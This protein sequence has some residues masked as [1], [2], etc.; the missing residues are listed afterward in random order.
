MKLPLI[1][2]V[3]FTLCLL[4]P[5][6]AYTQID[7]RFNLSNVIFYEVNADVEYGFNKFISAN[8]FGS[9]V[10]G[11]P[12]EEELEPYKKFSY[13]GLEAR[14]YPNP[15]GLIDGF[16]LGVY[17]KYSFGDLYTNM[18]SYNSNNQLYREVWQFNKLALGISLGSKWMIGDHFNVG[19]FGGVGRILTIQYQEPG[20]VEFAERFGLD[21]N[22]YDFRWG[23][24]VGYRF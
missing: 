4:V 2:K 8:L 6:L 22:L 15:K 12:V 13:L 17:T 11:L 18:Y 5:F 1:G 23:V 20:T 10:F 21:Q 16:Y 9:Y 7:A 3:C 19:F 14:I 24:M